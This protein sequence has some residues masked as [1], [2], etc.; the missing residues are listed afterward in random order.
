MKI[1][2][3]TNKSFLFK[4][5]VD[6]EF[7]GG[8]SKNILIKSGIFLVD[9][10]EFFEQDSKIYE[11]EIEDKIDDETLNLLKEW[12]I[13]HAE[14]KLIEYLSKMERTEYD[15][16][17]M[18]RKNEVPRNVITDLIKKAKDNK[19]LS[20]KRFAELF[21]EDSVMNEYR[22]M[23][24]KTRLLKKRIDDKIIEETIDKIYNKDTLNDIL[25]GT[26][27]KLLKNNATLPPQKIFEKVATALYRKGFEYAEYESILKKKIGLN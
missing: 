26:I 27:E 1:R 12:V 14:T 15:C 13:V 10:L 2:R 7:I 19:W 20:N 18:L 17:V 3:S 5:Y 4:V 24:V 25:K 6:D 23:D 11:I 9:K 16:D 8:I 21:A 22:P